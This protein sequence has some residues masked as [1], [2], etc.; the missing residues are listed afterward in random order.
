MSGQYIIPGTRTVVD[1]TVAN[2]SHK[3]RLF[4]DSIIQWLAQMGLRLC[5]QGNSV[6]VGSLLQRIR[7]IPNM[8]DDLCFPVFFG[9]L[10]LVACH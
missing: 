10:G 7:D 4:S 3:Q 2:T 6:P 1:P 5:R 9:S 8:P